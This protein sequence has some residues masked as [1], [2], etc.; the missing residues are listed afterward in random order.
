MEKLALDAKFET[1][2]ALGKTPAALAGFYDF[3]F[4]KVYEK[5]SCE[6]AKILAVELKDQEKII[7]L[8]ERENDEKALM[9]EYEIMGNFLKA[10]ELNEKLTLNSKSDIQTYLKVA[11]LYELAADM[12]DRDRILSKLIKKLKSDKKIDPKWVNPLYSTFREAGMLDGRMLTLAW[13]LE[14]KIQIAEMLDQNGGNKKAQ[15]LILSQSRQ[16]GP[17]WSKYI[18]SEVQD[19]YTKQEKI[20]FYGRY[21]ESRFKKRNKA[22]DSLALKAKSYLEG[23]GSR[24]RIY[25]LEI[26]KR[27][28]A[29]LAQEIVSTPLPD[30]LTPEILAQVQQNIQAMA[31][32]YLATS[33]D[34]ARLQK[35]Q[36]LQLDKASHE[37]V[38]ADLSGDSLN[39]SEKIM[40]E[41]QDIFTT[42]Q[43]ALG[44]REILLNKLASNPLDIKSLRGLENFYKSNESLRLASYFTGRINSLK[45]EHE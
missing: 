10:A 4:Q 9:V 2:V 20:G 26:L 38:L 31:E 41:T 30:D 36:F 23:A 17:M 16:T 18:L 40:L 3:C 1:I 11:V 6:N 29:N 19:L 25:L 35:E 24:T 27:A 8:L 33:Q 13:P 5:K 34:Y 43:I 39:F 37:N 45:E 44:D 42:D 32:P 15:K 28:Y 12:K 21:S 14:K 7:A 22:I